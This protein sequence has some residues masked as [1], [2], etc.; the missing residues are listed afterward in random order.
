MCAALLASC[1][2]GDDDNASSISGDE[3]LQR[4]RARESV[5]DGDLD[6]AALTF[7]GRKYESIA[8]SASSLDTDNAGLRLQALQARQ[9]LIETLGTMGSKGCDIP[10]DRQS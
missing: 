1:G 6:C 4:I 2:G 7:L 5:D 10:S 9:R 8:D 3:A